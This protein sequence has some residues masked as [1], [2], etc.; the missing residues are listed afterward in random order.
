MWNLIK[1]DTKGHICE[2]NKLTDFKTNL[3]VTV[4]DI[5]EGREELRG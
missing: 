3:M 5:V 2:R 4:G 1:N